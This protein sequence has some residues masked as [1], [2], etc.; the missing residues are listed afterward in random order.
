M[1]DAKPGLDFQYVLLMKSAFQL[2]SPC[3]NKHAHMQ[4]PN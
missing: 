2:T 3:F 4:H 1:G